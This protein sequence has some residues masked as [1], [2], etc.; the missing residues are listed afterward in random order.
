MLERFC[1]SIL[2]MLI[3]LYRHTLGHLLGGQCRYHPTCSAY[4]LEAL[5]TWG[6][7]RGTW[8]TLKR[9]ARCHPFARGGID[10]VPARS[11]GDTPQ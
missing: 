5:G 1:R 4:G 11:S 7:W 3:Q 9:L 6:A 8:L 2:V 10:P